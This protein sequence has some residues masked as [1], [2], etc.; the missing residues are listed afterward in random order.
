MLEFLLLTLDELLSELCGRANIDL[1]NDRH[2]LVEEGH[3]L[4][5]HLSEDLNAGRWI[6]KLFTVHA[7]QEL[8]DR[9][10]LLKFVELDDGF[11]PGGIQLLKLGLIRRYNIF[12]ETVQISV[13]CCIPCRILL[14]ILNQQL[15]DLRLKHESNVNEI[16]SELVKEASGALC[17]ESS[18]LIKVGA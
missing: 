16:F 17:L 18:K 14:S 8:P 5:L 9:V 10:S 2:S 13:L 1:F 3:L 12:M 11:F 4:L 6:H 15:V 7:I